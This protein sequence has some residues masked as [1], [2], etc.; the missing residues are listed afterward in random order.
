MLVVLIHMRI[1]FINFA[2][3]KRLGH[4][5]TLEQLSFKNFVGFFDKDSISFPQFK[6][7]ALLI[8]LME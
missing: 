7:A 5:D 4:T 1:Q 6:H 3:H 8:A 2:F